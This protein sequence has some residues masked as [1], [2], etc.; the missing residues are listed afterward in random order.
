MDATITTN[1]NFGTIGTTIALVSALCFISLIGPRKALAGETPLEYTYRQ[2]AKTVM[3]PDGGPW[4]NVELT[5]AT[6]AEISSQVLQFHG[7]YPGYPDYS[8]GPLRLVRAPL[9]LNP[10]GATQAQCQGQTSP[11]QPISDDDVD[12]IDGYLQKVADANVKTLLRFAYNYSASGKDAKMEI[13]LTD[14]AKLSKVVAKHRNVIYAL[15]AG[16]IGYWGEGHNS[17]CGTNCTNNTPLATDIF[18][19][20]EESAFGPYVTLLNRYPSNVMDWEPRNQVIWGIHDD[21]YAENERNTWIYA[22]WS[23]FPYS[24]DTMQHFGSAR[25]DEKPFSVEIG[26]ENP[27]LQ[28]YGPFNDLSERFH[29]NALDMAWNIKTLS[30]DEQFPQIINR[31]G[32]VIGLTKATLDVAP[33]RGLSSKLTLS[34]V[35]TG[36]SRLFTKVRAYLVMTDS[37]GNMLGNNVFPRVALPIDFTKLASSGGTDS[38]SADITFPIDLANNTSYF[39]ALQIVDPDPSLAG[40]VQY[41]Y[42]L[43]NAG[44]PNPSTGLNNLFAVHF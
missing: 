41:N 11:Q 39:V 1:R 32:P 43:N 22:K 8:V 6:V 19:K 3:N 12:K 2:P 36:Y 44:V 35:N 34:F 20:A 27:T 23:R 24:I 31:V 7:S 28:A 9:C 21:H 13:I 29:L 18:M 42:W 14:I 38:V 30:E 5:K 4:V 17:N 26:G 25:S 40:K 37:K 15:E 10:V 33:Q 16:F